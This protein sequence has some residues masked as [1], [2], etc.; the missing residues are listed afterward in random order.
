M[1]SEL[2]LEPTALA[3]WKQIIQQ[4]E[5][6]SQRV[7]DE[8]VE[9]YLIFTLMRFTQSPH[10]ASR[11]LAPEF[12]GSAQLTGAARQNRLRDVGDECLLLSG[13][14][15]QVA[16]RRLVQP[17]YYVQLGQTAYDHLGQLLQQA[18]AKLYQQLASCFVSMMDVLQHVRQDSSLMPL[19]AYD[20]WQQTG[21]RS[22]HRQLSENDAF[23]VT[24][25]GKRQH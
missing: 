9:S 16:E 19:Q 23:P 5:D 11:V 6:R 7:L 18:L 17:G 10:L 21:S 1:N 24:D 8:D 15:P 14:F 12:L 22:A 4:A 3:Q 13:L 2:L 25:S 20:L